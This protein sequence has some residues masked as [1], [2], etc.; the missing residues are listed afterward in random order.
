MCRVCVCWGSLYN[1]IIDLC[2]FQA[3]ELFLLYRGVDCILPYMKGSCKLLCS[4]TVHTY[5][6]LSSE[7]SELSTLEILLSSYHFSTSLL[8]SLTLTLTLSLTSLSTGCRFVITVPRDQA[9]V[10]DLLWS[11][12]RWLWHTDSGEVGHN[13]SDSLSDQVRS[14]S[15]Q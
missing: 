4:H 9:M 14:S 1:V 3:R 11:T 8:P 10:P 2:C 15:F 6:L 5:L 7:T 13:S 12:E